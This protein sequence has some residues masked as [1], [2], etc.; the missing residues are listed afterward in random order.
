MLCD[1]PIIL[2]ITQMIPTTT[3][4]TTITHSLLLKNKFITTMKILKVKVRVLAAWNIKPWGL[5]KPGS[6]LTS[7]LNKI[8]LQVSAQE[9]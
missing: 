5:V 8:K 7:A 6:Q 4:T 1:H 3:T 2:I 9:D